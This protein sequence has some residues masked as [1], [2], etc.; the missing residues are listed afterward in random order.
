MFRFETDTN[1]MSVS[2]TCRLWQAVTGGAG[3]RRLGDH[4]P[5]EQPRKLKE[6]EMLFVNSIYT[7]PC[8][9]RCWLLL[10]NTSNWQRANALDRR[11][12]V[13]SCG[14]SCFNDCSTEE[15][16]CR[17]KRTVN[18]TSLERISQCGHTAPV[19]TAYGH[20]FRIS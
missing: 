15:Q 12:F 5:I 11:F 6:F 18:Y 2:N 4:K 1:C 8:E 16:I 20:R 10:S 17:C 19:P 7:K 14:D 3:A 9:A 13:F